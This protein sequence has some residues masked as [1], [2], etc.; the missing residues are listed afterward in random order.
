MNCCEYVDKSMTVGFVFILV[1]SLG[2][3][4]VL[5]V[6]AVIIIVFF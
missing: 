6:N 4:N 2:F 5:F 3:V 1:E